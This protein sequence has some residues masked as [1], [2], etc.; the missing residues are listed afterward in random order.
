MGAGALL[1]GAHVATQVIAGSF[2]GVSQYSPLLVADHVTAFASWIALY[3]VEA[4]AIMAVLKRNDWKSGAAV[5]EEIRNLTTLPRKLLPIRSHIFK[6]LYNAG[7]TIKETVKPAPAPVMLAAA[8]TAS[9]DTDTDSP[10]TSSIPAATR[11]MSRSNGVGT[12]LPRKAPSPKRPPGQDEEENPHA[13][14][15]AKRA[16]ELRTREGYLKNVWYVAALS[17]KVG[18][19]PVK[20]QMCGKEMVLWR[21]KE[22]GAVRCI[23]NS[24]PHRGAPLSLGWV[25]EKEGHSCVVCPYHG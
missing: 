10:S 14:Q 25:E 7:K 5:A 12:I 24:C 22:T 11:T 3:A 4:V 18:S 16:K 6:N 13:A 17:E 9:T 21:E 2:P 23:D 15:H 1:E 8:S 19:K 20:V